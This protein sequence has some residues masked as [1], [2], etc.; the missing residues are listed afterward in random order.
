MIDRNQRDRWLTQDDA[1]LLADCL[2]DTYRS[3][4]PGGQHR[5]KVSSAV[6]LRHQ[7]TGLIVIAEEDRSQHTNKAKAIRRLRLAI[8]LHVRAPVPAPFAPPEVFREH[9]TAAGRIEV[10][11]RNPAY[12]VVVAAVLDVLAACGGQLR[13]S[14]AM[15]GLTTAQ[16]SR[17]IVGDG[18]V[19]DAANRLRH[20]AGLKPLS[21]R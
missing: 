12:P 15:L 6:R 9:V 5:N 4:G 21:V 17:F 13:E 20:A 1:A 14:A 16:L 7:P 11:R 19:L 10:S 8:A 18:K 3:R 2:V